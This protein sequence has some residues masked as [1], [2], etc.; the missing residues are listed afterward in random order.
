MAAGPVC[1]ADEAAAGRQVAQKWSDAVVKVQVVI[2]MTMS[3][4][5]ESEKREEKTET[6]GTVIDPSGLTVLSLMSM[7][8]GEVLGDLGS[9][10]NT[11]VSDVKIRLSD[12]T[13]VPGKIVLRDKDLD[14][15]FVRPSVKPDHPWDFIDLKQNGKVDVLDQ[16]V[17]IGRLGKVANRATAVELH[18]VQSVLEKPRKF[19]VIDGVAMAED[20]G[21]PV[22]TLDG[23]IVGIS[24]M[25]LAPGGLASRS[26]VVSDIVMGVVL[27]AE[28]II[29][30]AVQA[31]E[32]APKTAE[33]AVEKPSVKPVKMVVP[34]KQ[35]ASSKPKPK[36]KK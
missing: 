9:G 19:Y 27:P 15:A 7:N 4:G 8:P 2:K 35:P 28:D 24:L 34:S 16:V 17:T 3:A 5:G 33:A 36:A 11:E 25:R 31:P 21:G 23:K 6:V 29:T 32:D 22:G 1:A 10:M 12:G 30:V 14:L 20:V 13:E 26:R 18:R